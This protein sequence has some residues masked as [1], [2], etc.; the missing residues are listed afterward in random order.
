[1]TGFVVHGHIY[2]SD[3]NHISCSTMI[4]ANFRVLH[5]TKQQCMSYHL[6]EAHGAVVGHNSNEY[7]VVNNTG[8]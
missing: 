8:H 5:L 1:M 6:L 4:L 3:C 2:S 7:E